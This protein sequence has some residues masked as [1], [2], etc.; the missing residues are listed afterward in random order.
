[1][2]PGINDK[3]YEGELATFWFDENGILCALAKNTIRTLERQ[4]TNYDFIRK[5]TGNKKVCLLSDTSNSSPQDKETRDYIARELPG[6]FKAMA[7]ISTSTMG[8]F[9]ANV[10][11]ALKDQPIPI[12]F[13]DTEEKAK[14]WLKQFL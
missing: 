2:K 1:M 6:I 12:L 11:I 4:K 13:C 10:F 8:E 9:S 7:I 14:E 5:I 3:L